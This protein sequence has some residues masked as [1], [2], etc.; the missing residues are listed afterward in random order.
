[1]LGK[2]GKAQRAQKFLAGVKPDAHILCTTASGWVGRIQRG[3]TDI[4][5]VTMPMSTSGC[6]Y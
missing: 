1:M 5:T 2:G 3:M 4:S 6:I